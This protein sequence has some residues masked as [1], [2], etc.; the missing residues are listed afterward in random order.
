MKPADLPK[1]FKGADIVAIDCSFISLCK[2][3]PA[4]FS[5]LRRDGM[6]V[7]LIKPQFEAGKAEVDRG[8]GVIKDPAIH[9]RVISELKL[10][11]Q[12]FKGL[13]WRGTV[14][15]PLQGPKGN[16]EFFAWIEKK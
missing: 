7:A 16:V 11:I 12:D 13:E 14:K 4:A 8:A 1:Q 2:I 10:F 5:L 9:E 3:I 15:S 6:I